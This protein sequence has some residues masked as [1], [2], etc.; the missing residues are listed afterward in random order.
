M[1]ARITFFLDFFKFSVWPQS[2]GLFFLMFEI[3]I[4]DFT[5]KYAISDNG[6]VVFNN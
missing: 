3:Q 1:D 5:Y 6:R 4:F 2:T